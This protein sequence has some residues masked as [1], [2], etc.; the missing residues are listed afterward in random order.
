LDP[1][2]THVLRYDTIRDAILTCAQKLIYVSLIYRTEA[3]TK[4]WGI[5]TEKHKGISSE[6]LVNSFSTIRVGVIVGL[7]RVPKN[8]KLSFPV[9][10]R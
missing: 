2:W 6:V 8:P 10:F 4:K 3:T 1:P 9:R 7:H 5:K